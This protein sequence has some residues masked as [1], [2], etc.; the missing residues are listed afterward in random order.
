[1]NTLPIAEHFH[2]IQGEGSYVGTSMH[3]IRLAGCNVGKPNMAT[4]FA[5]GNQQED[6]ILPLLASGEKAFVCQSWDGRSFFCDT[7]FKS[8]Q[9]LSV[10]AL[11]EETWENHI[12]LTGGEPLI[13]LEKLINFGFFEQARVNHKV[14]HIET[15]GTISLPSYI[16]SLRDDKVV[17]ITVAPKFLAKAENLFFADEIKL[18]IDKDFVMNNVPETVLNHPNVYI[19][20]INYIDEVNRINVDYAM[21][22]LKSRPDWQLSCQWHK[23]LGVR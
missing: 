6:K 8:K 2:S 3:F 9:Q 12:C 14:V 18:L 15:S 22:V 20:P 4:V 17:W 19:S 7:D 21:E 13:H 11:M 10:E 16:L 23:F 1:M 5:S